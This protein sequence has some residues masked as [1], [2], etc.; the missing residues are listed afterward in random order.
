MFFN[1]HKTVLVLLVCLTF[2]G[3]AMASTI[4]SYHMMSM[5]IMSNNEGSHNMMPMMDHSNHNMM[6]ESSDSDTSCSEECCG[7]TCSCFS[8]GCSNLATLMKYSVN[9]PIIDSSLKIPSYLALAVSQQP[10]S[11][12]RPPILS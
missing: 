2:V 12:Y 9:N 3:Q 5:E 4:M 7:K 1:F 8:S 10:T 6:N 11:L